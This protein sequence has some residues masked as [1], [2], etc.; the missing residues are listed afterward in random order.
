MG[1]PPSPYSPQFITSIER[2]VTRERLRRYLVAVHQD[3]A[4]ALLL[5]EYNVA[6]SEALFGLLHGLEVTLRNAIHCQ[7]TASYGNAS[8]YD[9]APLSPYWSAQVADAKNKVGA[10]PGKI[11]AE[12]TFGFWVEL[13]SRPNHNVLWAGRKLNRAFPHA[14]CSRAAI[15]RRLKTIHRLRNRIS[16]HE[17]VLTSRKTLYAGYE[18]ITT[19]ELLECVEWICTEAAGW[20]KTRFRYEEANCILDAVCGSGVSL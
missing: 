7:L 2:T 10:I 15:H 16:H 11:I 18:F 6:L 3:V 20:M 5:Y 9:S 19:A 14:T 17:A 8:W 13:V 1:L 12:L 4:K